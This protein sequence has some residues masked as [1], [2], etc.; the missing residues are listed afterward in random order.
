MHTDLQQTQDGFSYFFLFF[1]VS[2][3]VLISPLCMR[4]RTLVVSD[5]RNQIT[6]SCSSSLLRNGQTHTSVHEPPPEWNMRC[7]RLG[8]FKT[9][10]VR[11]WP[12]N[13]LWSSQDHRSSRWISV[14]RTMTTKFKKDAGARRGSD[15]SSMCSQT[16]FCPSHMI[17]YYIMHEA[18]MSVLA[19]LS[20]HRTESANKKV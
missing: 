19:R 14:F 4:T 11:Q 17:K 16:I 18:H 3:C 8:S 9:Y 2:R 15:S 5:N 7:S 6:S 10:P 12:I 20:P 1:S 13:V